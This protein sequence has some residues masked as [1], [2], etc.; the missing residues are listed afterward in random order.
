MDTSSLQPTY[1][2][3]QALLE[4]IQTSAQAQ[5]FAIRVR[6][7]MRFSEELGTHTR[8]DLCCVCF[9]SP[10]VALKIQRRGQRATL[11]CNCP[12]TAKALFLRPTRLWELTISNPTHNHAGHDRSA[13]IASER[14]RLRT[15][16]PD[17]EA[18]VERLSLAG[19]KTA[20]EIAEELEGIYM[21]NGVRTVRVTLRDVINIQQGLI[22]KKYGP[23]SSTQIFLEILESTPDIYHRTHR[24]AEGQVDA[25]FF[26]F[27][28]A[29]QHWQKSQ[30]ILSFDCT[31]RVNRFDMP[32]LQVTG[33]TALNTTFTIAFCLVGA[34]KEPDFRWA[35][36]KLRDLAQE[37]NIR[38]PLVILSDKDSAFKKAALTVFPNSQQ[39]LCVWHILKNSV[40]HIHN[41]WTKQR[42]HQQAK[43]TQ[44]AE[45][46]DSDEESDQNDREID[47]LVGTEA[48]DASNASNI[49]NNTQDECIRAWTACVHAPAE[50][51][52]HSRWEALKERFSN[53]PGMFPP[54]NQTI[55]MKF[56]ALVC[57]FA[58]L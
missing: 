36:E 1:Q 11:R 7:S 37:R 42:D 14:R 54:F 33:T 43:Q 58:H 6:R 32:L 39:Q 57:I 31:Y 35:L 48:S 52:F 53:Q 55:S 30:E 13:E 46:S 26:A 38:H 23:L 15:A 2:S 18:H 22:R 29:L 56:K 8:Y 49:N 17:F 40:H 27:N 51:D 3:Y 12:F 24:A 20:R 44:P 34:E 5:G 21:E 50:E 25:V 9:G 28:A 41:K 10:S 45:E 47:A 16:E 4:A 19:T